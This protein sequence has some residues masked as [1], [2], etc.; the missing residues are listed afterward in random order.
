[1]SNASCSFARLLSVM[2]CR[3]GASVQYVLL[4]SPYQ[5]LTLIAKLAHQLT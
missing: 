1:M 4:G 5:S 3:G 2:F